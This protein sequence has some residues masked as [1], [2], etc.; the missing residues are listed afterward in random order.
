MPCPDENEKWLIFRLIWPMHLK[1][2]LEKRSLHLI[3]LSTLIAFC[4]E[5]IQWHQKYPI[6]ERKGIS[7]A[8]FNDL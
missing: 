4:L 6:Y 8:Y 7:L 3:L 2:A 1:S 5:N